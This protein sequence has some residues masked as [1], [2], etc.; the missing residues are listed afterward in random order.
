MATRHLASSPGDF[1]GLHLLGIALCHCGKVDEGRRNVEKAISLRP[2]HPDPYY[3]LGTTLLQLQEWDSAKHYL[4]QAITLA[5]GHY[6]AWNSLGLIHMHEGNPAEAAGAY[7]KAVRLNPDFAGAW[8]NLASA[9][10]ERNEKREGIRALREALRL[11]PGHQGAMEALG[12]LLVEEGRVSEARELLER[13]L[14]SGAK[15]AELLQTLGILCIQLTDYETARTHLSE[16]LRL[17]P[18]LHTARDELGVALSNLGRPAEARSCHEAVLEAQ[19]SHARAW[20]HLAEL[21]EMTNNPKEAEELADRGLVAFPRHPVLTLVKAKCERRLR[22]T[23]RALK[24][25]QHLKADSA[26][27]AP[28]LRA[29]HFELG[30]CHDARNEPAEAMREFS[31]GNRRALMAW[32]AGGG[33]NDPVLP[34]A[35]YL[36]QQFK[37]SHQPVQQQPAVSPAAQ[38]AFV[39]GFQRSGTTLLD[40]ILDTHSQVQVVEESPALMN[41]ASGFARSYAYPQG[42]ANL[43][44]AALSQLRRTYLQAIEADAALDG[45]KLVVDKSPLNFIHLGLIRALFPD[46]PIILLVRDPRDVCLSCFIQDFELSPF[47]ARLCSLEETAQAYAALMSLQLHYEKVLALNLLRVRYEDLVLDFDGQVRRVLQ[48][49][50]L[51]WEPGLSRFYDH[52]KERGLVRTPSYHQVSQ[53]IYGSSVGRWRSYAHH[54]RPLEPLLAPFVEHFGYAH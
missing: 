18:D 37:R 34:A 39:V 20:G 22:R 35:Q 21:L 10:T 54:I 46:A 32:Q 49:V 30:R 3:N 42:M 51:N 31:E 40:T 44:E 52:A 24:R 11:E 48:H 19:P 26:A 25:L 1:D 13:A 43:T 5:P 47:T 27:E 2:K 50:A 4:N 45:D 41:T 7:R 53:P 15:T 14:R 29:V 38:L 12:S 17:K 36:R 9:L 33:R 23:D 8:R 16:A 28:Y 6:S